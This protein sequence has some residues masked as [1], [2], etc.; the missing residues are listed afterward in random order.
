MFKTLCRLSLALCAGHSAASYAGPDP[1]DDFEFNRCNLDTGSRWDNSQTGTYIIPIRDYYVPRDLPIGGLIGSIGKD[2]VRFGTNNLEGF[3]I[4]CNR[5]PAAPP[6]PKP[7]FVSDL[8]ATAPLYGGTVPSFNGQDLTGKV[9]MTSAEGVGVAL[10]MYGPYE[11]DRIP[12]SFTP[13]G[14]SRIAPFR[15]YNRNYS[16]NEVVSVGQLQIT[17]ILIKIGN[18]PPGRQTID[19]R[20][21]LQASLMP[22]L[23]KAFTVAITGS[24][25]SASCTLN[26]A[27]PVSDTPVKLGEWSTD[28]FNGP[29]SATTAVPFHINLLDCGDNP[30]PGSGFFQDEMGFAMA[31]IRLEGA[32]GSTIVDKDQGLFSLDSNSSARGVGIQ[33][34][35][36][37]GLTPVKLGEDTPVKRIASAGPMQLDFTARLRQLPGSGTVTAGSANGALNFTISYQ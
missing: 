18:I 24:V 6:D 29:D 2:G 15:A 22:D 16:T 27:N 19:D 8:Q 34:L 37:D 3:I 26:P 12:A 20:Q 9:F 32:A 21:L 25:T 28:H 1:V 23:R 13:E 5:N 33:M 11:S 31:H 36:Q 17:P 14:G 30:N 4:N 7:E 10:M 35:M